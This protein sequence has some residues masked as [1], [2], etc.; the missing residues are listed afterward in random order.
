MNALPTLLEPYH[1]ISKIS[2]SA[3]SVH[4]QDQRI[5]R[6]SASAASA[7]QQHQCISR[8]I[9]SAA[10]VHQRINSIITSA[11]ST[12]QFKIKVEKIALERADP[13]HHSAASMHQQHQ[14]VSSISKI[15]SSAGSAH[16]Q[17][18]RNIAS[19]GSMHQQ[20]QRISWI[21]A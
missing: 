21:S 4:Q 3:G 15:R 20:D 6:I 16:Q 14:F 1:L 18:Q 12:N 2:A 17:D 9:T 7:H 19:A 10:S 13:D 8:V 5:N 11:A